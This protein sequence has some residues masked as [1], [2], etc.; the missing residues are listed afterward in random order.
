M[1]PSHLLILG[2]LPTLAGCGSTDI[3]DLQGHW[4][5]TITCFTGKSDLST[6]LTVTGNTV[7]GS[8]EIRTNG[9]NANYSVS[10]TQSVVSRLVE[11]TST[12]ICTGG[13]DCAKVLDKN[14]NAGSSACLQGYCLPCFEKTDQKQVIIVL[15]H[16]N[17][18]IVYPRLE[19][20]RFGGTLM[21]GT[22]KHFCTDEDRLTPKVTLN[23]H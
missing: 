9:S 6:G 11:C 3:A 16:Q 13:P 17:P 20:W 14:G 7:S 8:G 15:Q 21:E 18:T 2:F 23:K 12:P 5:G 4:S 22:I 19:L 1:R 10:G